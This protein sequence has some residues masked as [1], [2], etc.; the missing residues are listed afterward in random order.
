MT[1]VAFVGLG[2]M[3]GPMADHVIRA[4]T[5]VRVFDP[6]GEA[7][8]ARVDARGHGCSSVGEAADG[9]DV[10]CVVVR[11]D[12]QTLDVTEQA[13][14]AASPGAVVVVH[15]TVSLETVRRAHACCVDGGLD[16]IDA[17]ISG[18]GHGALAGALTIMAGGH[19]SAVDSA[20]PVMD[21][22]S[23]RIVHLGPLGAGMTA[24]L[25]RNLIGYGVMA[26]AH[27]G[28]VLADAGGVDLDAFRKLLDDTTDTLLMQLAAVAGRP[29][30]EPAP[31][32]SD[33]HD[34]LVGLLEIGHKDLFLAARAAVELGVEI[35]TAAVAQRLYGPSL[36]ADVPIDGRMRLD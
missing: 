35:P 22:Y 13:V 27:D 23:E 8:A 21:T 18:G 15:S 30:V 10:V 29:T 5:D 19:P 32:G 9:A 4:G 25:A 12:A 34:G 11:D 1:V 24:K 17:G 3:G 6:R 31:A 26:A 33:R 16:L 36:G 28:M 2:E 7:V 14:T 20:R